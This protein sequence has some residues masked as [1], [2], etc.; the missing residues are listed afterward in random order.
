[1]NR[2]KTDKLLREKLRKLEESPGIEYFDQE[3]SWEQMASRLRQ[4]NGHRLGWLK[5]AAAIFICLFAFYGLIHYKQGE[6]KVE[7]RKEPAQVIAEKNG[8]K[9]KTAEKSKKEPGLQEKSLQ[10]KKNYTQ[11]KISKKRIK[12]KNT[13]IK[14]IPIDSPSVQSIASTKFVNPDTVTLKQPEKI[15]SKKDV[16]GKENTSIVYYNAIISSQ[17]ESSSKTQ[18]TFNLSFPLS[19]SEPVKQNLLADNQTFFINHIKIN[20]S[21]KN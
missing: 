19:K 2:D 14:S 4:N 11:I 17:N 12:R 5:Y 8:S 18:K 7:K 15:D 3:K 13:T 16:S 6:R 10:L 20:I 9:Q 21:P 1:M